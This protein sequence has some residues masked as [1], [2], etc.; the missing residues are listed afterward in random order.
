MVSPAV[1]VSTTVLRVRDI[2]FDAPVALLA[3][4]GLTL[5]RVAAREHLRADQPGLAFAPVA[6]GDRL[7]VG[8]AGECE[9]VAREQRRGRVE[10]DIADAEDIGRSGARSDPT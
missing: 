6:A 3:T 2:G 1:D 9:A 7:A 5:V 8:H 10:A 4:L